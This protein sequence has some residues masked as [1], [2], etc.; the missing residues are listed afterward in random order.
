MPAKTKPKSKSK[1]ASGGAKS[2]SRL[3]RIVF[4]LLAALIVVSASAFAYNQYQGNKITAL[5]ANNR[6]EVF[7]AANGAFAINA[8]YR[9]VST[10][11]V[12]IYKIP[13][14]STKRYGWT[15]SYAFGPDGQRMV[16]GEGWYNG[17]VNALEI[18][19]AGFDFIVVGFDQ[20]GTG[21]WQTEY[22]HV[23]NLN[24]EK[25]PFCL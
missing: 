10:R 12:F 20:R 24:Y 18:D 22:K 14:D 8:C 13:L 11:I 23:V 25:I 21:P 15:R 7:S 17:V 5:A 2:T 9:N 6:Y 3:K 4:I 1:V 19:R 16:R